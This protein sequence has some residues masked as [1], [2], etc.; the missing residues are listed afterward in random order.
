[1][2]VYLKISPVGVAFTTTLSVSASHVTPRRKIVTLE[3]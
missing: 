1:M 3:R 2:E